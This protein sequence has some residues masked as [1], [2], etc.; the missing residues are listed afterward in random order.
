MIYILKISCPSLISKAIHIFVIQFG[1]HKNYTEEKEN[2]PLSYHP[3]R[4]FGNIPRICMCVLQ[5]QIMQHRSQEFTCQ[6]CNRSGIIGVLVIVTIQRA[7]AG[8]KRS[9]PPIS[10]S[11]LLPGGRA[12]RIAKSPGF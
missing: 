7:H 6:Q 9:R 12:L 11:S 5:N 2:H 8:L 3:V 10:W 1:K 4:S